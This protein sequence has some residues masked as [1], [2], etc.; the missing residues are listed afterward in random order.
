M[1]DNHLEESLVKLLLSKIF[2]YN[3]TDWHVIVLDYRLYKF[4]RRK[5]HDEFRL[6]W[7]KVFAL[8]L[9]DLRI[10]E[11]GLHKILH[12]RISARRCN[13]FECGLVLSV[14]LGVYRVEI[15][16]VHAWL[17]DFECFAEL[18]IASKRMQSVII[19]G[20]ANF[21]NGLEKATY[22]P[23]NFEMELTILSEMSQ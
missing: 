21:E 4:P 12:L 7:R 20:F 11:I 16:A 14:V 22:L 19:W 6:P 9:S 8:R 13:S 2:L 1:H 23:T 17:C 15:L 18:S 3:A 5:A 10:T